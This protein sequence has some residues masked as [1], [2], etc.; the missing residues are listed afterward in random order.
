VEASEIQTDERG[1]TTTY[2]D[3]LQN[4]GFPLDDDVGRKVDEAS[5]EK[6]TD[7]RDRYLQLVDSLHAATASEEHP[8]GDLSVE[9]MAQVSKLKLGRVFKCPEPREGE[10]RPLFPGGNL[11]A[12]SKG[13]L[14]GGRGN[15]FDTLELETR[16]TRLKGVL[17][18]AHSIAISD[19][20]LYAN[21]FFAPRWNDED[22]QIS[23]RRLKNY[24]TFLAAIRGLIENN[25]VILYPQYEH[26]GLGFRRHR[27]FF[28]QQFHDWICDEAEVAVPATHKDGRMGNYRITYPDRLY[29][30]STVVK[31]LLFF[32]GRYGA[33]PVLPPTSDNLCQA[34]LKYLIQYGKRLASKQEVEN[35]AMA[36]KIARI[37]I[38]ELKN[39]PLKDLIS[40]RRND[41]VFEEWR[42]LLATAI[43]DIDNIETADPKEV[44]VHVREL[45]RMGQEK[46]QTVT[47]K[48]GFFQ[49]LAGP[50]VTFSLG[51]IGAEIL[52][53]AVDPA[54]LG[55]SAGLTFIYQYLAGSKKREAHKALRK[56][57]ATLES[58][59]EEEETAVST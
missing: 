50:S 30:A 54:T 17:L 59:A 21:E 51:V 2:L 31:E 37:D 12:F 16:L 46:V 3:F 22:F 20:L 47:E 28:D 11:G 10:F 19:G 18:Y 26:G 15:D 36:D 43:S 55:M 48:S 39:L 1:P 45:L 25:I 33:C 49:T 40:I 29:G 14:A 56:H 57:F 58:S 6:L 5:R 32:A 52:K 23:K 34:A 27:A 9:E 44:S 53:G 8:L 4:A 7:F 13:T 24:L 38:P 35:M 42:T 41:E